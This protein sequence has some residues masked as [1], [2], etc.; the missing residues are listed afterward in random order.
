VV[1]YLSAAPTALW[2]GP[3]RPPTVRE[4]KVWDSGFNGG[5]AKVG[6]NTIHD[7]VFGVSAFRRRAVS[8]RRLTD[9]DAQGGVCLA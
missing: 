7:S 5:C 8:A 2:I 9:G 4:R 6:C 3:F 1:S